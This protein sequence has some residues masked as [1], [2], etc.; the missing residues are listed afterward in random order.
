MVAF[1]NQISNVMSNRLYYYGFRKNMDLIKLSAKQPAIFQI[2]FIV[3]ATVQN[4]TPIIFATGEKLHMY[5]V[6]ETNALHLPCE[7]INQIMTVARGYNV[8]LEILCD[9]LVLT[10]LCEDVH[11]NNIQ[12][13]VSM[14]QRKLEEMDIPN[15]INEKYE[16]YKTKMR[17]AFT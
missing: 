10:V 8:A 4:I 13:D 6:F 15:E 12:I 7:V 17:N 2:F 9:N 11:Q 14:L 5:I 16:R 1:M 3:Y